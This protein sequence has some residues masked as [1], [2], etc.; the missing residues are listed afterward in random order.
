MPLRLLYYMQLGFS[1]YFS[2]PRGSIEQLVKCEKMECEGNSI[3]GDRRGKYKRAI[4]QCGVHKRS[5]HVK[6]FNQKRFSSFTLE[7]SI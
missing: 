7:H 5:M 4:A 2:R 6:T 1:V 3:T